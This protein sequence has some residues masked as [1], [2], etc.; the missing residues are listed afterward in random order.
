[1]HKGQTYEGLYLNIH[2]NTLLVLYDEY[3]HTHEHEYEH[4]HE[5]EYEHTHESTHRTPPIMLR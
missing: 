4:T 5:H 2:M 1:M 3:E